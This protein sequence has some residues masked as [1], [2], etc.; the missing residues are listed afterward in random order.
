MSHFQALWTQIENVKS[1]GAM[2]TSFQTFNGIKTLNKTGTEWVAANSSN[3]STYQAENKERERERKIPVK[4][5]FNGWDKKFN[6]K[7]FGSQITFSVASMQPLHGNPCW[8][9][10]LQGFFFFG[11]TFP[12]STAYFIQE[13]HSHYNERFLRMLKLDSS[14]NDTL[15]RVDLIWSTSVEQWKYMNMGNS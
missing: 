2:E 12:N 7:L 6:L 15:E 3:N 4:K 8:T 5:S 10:G 14:K 9:G 11:C 13:L 1:S